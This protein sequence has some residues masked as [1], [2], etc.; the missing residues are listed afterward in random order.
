M[1]SDKDEFDENEQPC[2]PNPDI[3]TNEDGIR[4]CRNCGLTFGQAFVESERSGLYE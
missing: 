1:F 3:V 4:V 2:C